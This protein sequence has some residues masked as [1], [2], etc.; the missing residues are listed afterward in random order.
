MHLLGLPDDVL[1]GILNQ[2][3]MPRDKLTL[4]MVCKRLRKCEMTQAAWSNIERLVLTYYDHMTIFYDEL[5]R[6][7]KDKYTSTVSKVKGNTFYLTCSVV[8][9]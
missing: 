4:G 1:I 7:S 6:S 5:A 2:L 9:H 3:R 8:D